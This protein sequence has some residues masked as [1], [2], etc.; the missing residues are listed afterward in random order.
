MEQQVQLNLARKWRSKTFGE[1][2]GQR[3][4]VETLTAGLRKGFFFPVYLLTGMRGTGKTSVG[5]IFGAAINCR[6][7]EDFQRGELSNAEFPCQCCDSCLAMGNGSH[8][9][10]IEIDA[11]SHTG[12]DHVR[13]IV[14]EA[15]FLP[16][17]GRWKVYLID[18]VHMLS[19]AAS[20]AFLKVLEEPPASAL[21]LL[22]TTDH[23]K[24]LETVR[25]R[26]FQLFFE[27]IAPV[28][29]ST[30]LAMICG[31]E[32]ITFDEAGLSLVAKRS[33]GALRDA[34]NLIE[35][36]R[37]LP[38]GVTA[39]G[40]RQICND[41]D[42]EQVVT[43]LECLGRGI[44]S[45]DLFDFL[46]ENR[47]DS[48]RPALIWERLVEGLRVFLWARYDRYTETYAVSN[49][50]IAAV[51]GLFSVD[52][53]I[54]LLDLFYRSEPLFIKTSAQQVVL[55][56]L[57]LGVIARCNRPVVVRESKSE[58]DISEVGVSLAPKKEIKEERRTVAQNPWQDFLHLVN[59][60]D[61]DPLVRTVL[62]Q[63]E[64]TLW[65]DGM[66][67]VTFPK[68]FHLYQE[69]LVLRRSW[70]QPLLEKVFGVGATLVPDFSGD[71]IARSSEQR[72]AS[73]FPAQRQTTGSPSV[74]RE[75]RISYPRRSS[76]FAKKPKV[77]RKSEVVVPGE[78][79]EWRQA[80]ALAELFPGTITVLQEGGYE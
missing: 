10:F 54:D 17:M 59:K 57:L 30:Y 67:R 68:K 22:A 28:E 62:S 43:L 74:N 21:F 65:D 39:S 70:W 58:S 48:Y 13:Q 29:M 76:E 15:A 45:P 24:I 32:G 36:A 37:F 61:G 55:E 12:V 11:A 1:I 31:R 42:D 50:R 53:L 7:F 5:R 79:E 44:S 46:K 35:R 71:V 20:N 49:D 19:K 77:L 63:G 6:R 18:E 16:V 64:C 2:V 60:M 3:L 33:G 66:V 69:Q 75:Q 26:S 8:P 56:R 73:E 78:G 72:D 25:S 23:H 27:S 51:A 41:I 40:I 47:F 38:H 4:V 34:L 52:E 9:D 80:R 14:D